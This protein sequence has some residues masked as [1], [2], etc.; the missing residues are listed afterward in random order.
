MPVRILPALVIASVAAGVAVTAF[1]NPVRHA[2]RWQ[3][4][5]DGGKPLVFCSRED[6]TLD[7]ASIT[8]QMS[9]LP[10]ASCKTT[11]F[12][13][14]DTSAT[15]ALECTINGSKM[16][17]SGTITMTGPDSVTAKIHSH[18]GAFPMADGK[19]VALPDTDTTTV[20]TRLGP[21][22][23]GDPESKF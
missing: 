11:S 15:Y 3:T 14:T 21:C 12:S 9:Q 13:A 2:G 10:G 7:E 16:T 5:I 1:A 22:Q 18:G 4:V 19:T 8:K 23:P 17:T 6:R 20:S